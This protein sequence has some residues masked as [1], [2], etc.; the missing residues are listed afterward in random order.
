M[1]DLGGGDGVGG[2][3]GTGGADVVAGFCQLSG[4][5]VMPDLRDEFDAV[6]GT[7]GTVVSCWHEAQRT[8]RPAN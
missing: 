6:G 7:P 8:S 2:A 1:P 5:K 4:T 3:G